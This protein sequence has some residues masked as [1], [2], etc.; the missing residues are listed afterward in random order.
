MTSQS[1]QADL[2]AEARRLMERAGRERDPDVADR[3]RGAAG[4]LLGTPTRDVRRSW[5]AKGL[6][7]RNETLR[8]GASSLLTDLAP[9]Q[10]GDALAR[11]MRRYAAG[12][13]WGRDQH[14]VTCPPAIRGTIEGVVWCAWKAH[15]VELL[16][17]SYIAKILRGVR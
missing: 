17:G 3:Y 7:E 16:S 12:P 5:R 11:A 9:E 14:A 4:V 15:R 8:A 10:Q 2:I 1:A 6:R 13:R